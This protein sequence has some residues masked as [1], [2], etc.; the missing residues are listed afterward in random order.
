[1][2]RSARS[3]LTTAAVLVGVAVATALGSPTLIGQ[4][5]PLGRAGEDAT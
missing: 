5:P 4:E 2:A 1:M 3:V